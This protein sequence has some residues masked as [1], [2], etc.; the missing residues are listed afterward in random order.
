MTN[1]RILFL[2]IIIAAIAVN[3]QAQ[4]K[5]WFQVYGFAMTDIG[6]DFKQIHPDWYD[7]VRPTKLP[8]YENEYGTDGNAYFSVRQTRFGVKSST[9]T[10]LGELFTQFEWELF[11]TGVDA[12]QTTIRL[13]HAYGELGCIGVGQYWSPFMDIDVF[14]NTVEYWGPNGMAFFRN[15]QFRYMPIKGDTRLTFALE[16]PGASADG[17]V[18]SE[19]LQEQNIDAQFPVPDFSAE[20][21]S[22]HD[23]GYVEL[24]G[25][26][27]Y[28][29]WKDQ[30]ADSIDLSGDAIGW[31]LNLSSNIKITQNDIA[32]LSV[33]YGAGV[34][35]YMNDATVDVG[36]ETTND[37]EKPVKGV[38]IPL[39]GVVAFL[40]HNWSDKFATAI[41]YSMLS[42]DNTNGQSYGAFKM[43]NYAIGNLIYYP[44]ENVMMVAE[45]QYGNRDNFNNLEA[46]QE[47]PEEYLKTS[48]ILKLQFS[49][50]YNFSHKILF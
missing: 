27:R 6:Y 35:N 33:L 9:Q 17:G 49:F 28:M 23:W 36:I 2:T 32:R 44:V 5:N 43:G 22:A 29:K 26:V 3:L 14:P 38:A 18:Y 19:I 37:P 42:M 50:K 10:G 45:L 12:G 31:G 7:V 8:T 41:G 48:D 24:A 16:R 20:Y 1:Y 13:R 4:D 34:Q 40:E 11:G 47:Y 15:I 25:I 30:G 21:R 39:L 46:G